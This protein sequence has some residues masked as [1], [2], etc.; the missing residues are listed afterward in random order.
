MT[1][2]KMPSTHRTIQI[3]IPIRVA[4]HCHNLHFLAFFA[5]VGIP[6]ALRVEISDN[7]PMSIILYIAFGLALLLAPLPD[8]RALDAFTPSA[9]MN[10][11]LIGPHVEYFEDASKQLTLEEV[12]SEVFRS[13]FVP[14]RSDHISLGLSR[15]A[16][17]FRMTVTN[18]T[19][20]VIEWIMRAENP[21]V[22]NIEVYEIDQSGPPRLHAGGSQISFSQREISFRK[23]SFAMV[24]PPGVGEV[25]IKAWPRALV[26][27]NYSLTAWG[28][29]PFIADAGT[30]T[31]LLGLLCGALLV[32]CLYNLFIYLSL[33]DPAYLLY[34]A[35]IFFSLLGAF[36]HFGFAHQYLWPDSARMGIWGAPGFQM[37]SFIFAILFSRK[38]LDIGGSASRLDRLMWIYVALFALDMALWLGDERSLA[39]A[40]PLAFALLLT[41]PLVLVYAGVRSLR[42][43]LR[44]ARFYVVAWA[45]FLLAILAF[46]TT[47]HVIA[48]YHPAA[49]MYMPYMIPIGTL[50]DVILLSFALA[51]RIK[52]LHEER[53]VMQSM[54]NEYLASNNAELDAQVALKT[55]D[56]QKARKEAE[57]ARES[58]ERTLAEQRQFM[59]ML[60]HEYRSPLAVIDAAAR[61]LEVKLPAG[62][63]TTPILARIQRGV[64][65][66]TNLLDDCLTNDRLDCDALRVSHSAIDLYAF[67]A[68]IRE[69]VQFLS[70]NHRIVTEIDPD[71]PLLD[72]DPK[73][74]HILL[75]NL[76]GN[77]IKYS[78]LGGEV[79][80][81]ITLSGQACV[82]VV[83]D[84]GQGIPAD[85]LPLVFDK[86]VRGRAATA[87]V[88]AGLGLSL[89]SR[90]VTLHGG[91]VEIAS[92]EGEWTRVTVSIPLRRVS[93]QEGAPQS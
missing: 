23:N 61:L 38:F 26:P 11:A 33:R 52:I 75:I 80:L 73:L 53:T 40:A 6:C 12:R 81:R 29:K 1:F 55:V 15:S 74:L 49:L 59:A 30:D 64:S 21:Y 16:H 69:D 65:R 89:V 60:S 68:S 28:T 31:L 27:A 47:P 62:S 44:Q 71:I 9:S 22:H 85:E 18:P 10:G 84:E 42:A 79:R 39:Y 86:Y 2:G 5:L 77:A 82:F 43:G 36:A 57:A 56:H 41:F 87:V 90:I 46:I 83:T 20:D 34:V 17:W 51:D 35:Y 45:I 63:N 91:R 3:F 7:D 19:E 25:Y 92:R 14:V 93:G 78:P 88:G 13:R 67:A 54:I 66:L 8:A 24:T 37:L 58:A 4:R 32:M 50:I 72:A 70:E 76:L 48:P